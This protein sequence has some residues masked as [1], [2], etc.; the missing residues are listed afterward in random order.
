MLR[1]QIDGRFSVTDA[2][3]EDAVPIKSRKARALLA[4][5]AL[6][7]RQGSA[8]VKRSWPCSGPHGA[9]SRRG[10]PCV[11]SSAPCARSSVTAGMAAL[12]ITDEALSA[13]SRRS[14][15][16]EASCTRRPAAGRPS[17]QRPGL[18]RL[19]AGRA[20]A[21]PRTRP[22]SQAPGDRTSDRGGKPSIV[23]LP[24]ANLSADPEQQYFSDGITQDIMTELS[25][26]GSFDVLARQSAFVLRDRA[27]KI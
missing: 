3:G 9:R 20:S 1:L 16:I 26:F 4:Y 8:A 27:R 10:A 15:L 23:V 19:A 22:A 2:R 18:R 13:R 11:R 12:Q 21:Q 17:D 14:V 6:P 7:G 5:L 25:R 24:F